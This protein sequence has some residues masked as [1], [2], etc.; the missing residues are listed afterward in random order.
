V[1]TFRFFD[2]GTIEAVLALEAVRREREDRYDRHV[3]PLERKRDQLIARVG[4]RFRALTDG[5][6]VQAEG[7]LAAIRVSRAL[8]GEAKDQ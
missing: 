1:L 2:F 8:R 4:T 5:Q 6:Q 3:R 7:I